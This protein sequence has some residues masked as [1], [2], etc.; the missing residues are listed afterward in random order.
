V[1]TISAARIGFVEEA[2]IRIG[3]KYHAAW[4][5]DN[6]VIWIGINIVKEEVYRL[7][8]GNGGLGL[9]GSNG[10]ESYE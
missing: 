8:C 1:S 9:A 6:V 3:T 4:S 2:C 10:T 5:I 7:F